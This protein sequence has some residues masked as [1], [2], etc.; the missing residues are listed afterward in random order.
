MIA[1]IMKNINLRPINHFR[2]DKHQISHTTSFTIELKA[3]CV[4]KNYYFYKIY[5][6]HALKKIKQFLN[7]A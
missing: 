1:K 2:I 5:L 7:H 4:S 6:S 3:I